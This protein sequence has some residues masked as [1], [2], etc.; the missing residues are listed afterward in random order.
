MK[1]LSLKK[2]FKILNY[3]LNYLKSK[4]NYE[5]SSKKNF[6]FYLTKL[7]IEIELF[8]KINY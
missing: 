1:N 5:N 3:Y 2:F 8:D 4:K 6:F 7:I